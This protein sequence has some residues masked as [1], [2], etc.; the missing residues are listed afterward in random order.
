VK[1]EG[2]IF[3]E[4]EEFFILEKDIEKLEEE[5]ENLEVLFS[6]DALP[7]K[8][9]K[10]HIRYSAIDKELQIKMERWEELA[11]FMDL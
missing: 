2:Y 9:T 7:E 3:K 1:K 5:K 10:A 11:E 8:I 6:S 4:K